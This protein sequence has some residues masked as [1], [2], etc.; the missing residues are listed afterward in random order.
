MPFTS[1]GE[2]EAF[3][4]GYELSVCVC[5]SHSVR[6][7]LAFRKGAWFSRRVTVE[8]GGV[9]GLDDQRVGGLSG[10]G[11]DGVPWVG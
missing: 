8:S 3:V 7:E 6:T 1:L 10:Q 4:Q 11:K 9:A 2:L 5:V